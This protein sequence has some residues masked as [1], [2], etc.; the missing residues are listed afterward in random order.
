M[1]VIFFFNEYSKNILD[2]ISSKK[3]IE[4]NKNLYEATALVKLWR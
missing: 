1:L 4:L 2:Y 3:E